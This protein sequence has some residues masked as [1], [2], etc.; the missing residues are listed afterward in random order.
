[1]SSLRAKK[2]GRY[3]TPP[4]LA[5]PLVEW[6][7]RDEKTRFLDPSFGGC[8]FLVAAAERLRG[9]GAKVPGRRVYGVDIDKRARDYL[10]PLYQAGALGSNFLTTDFLA[11]EPG[12]IP[13]GPFDTVCGNPPYVR[14]DLIADRK[15]ET[16]IDATCGANVTVPRNA[17]YWAYF[18]IHSIRCL[19]FGGR[20]AMI[21]P[22]SFLYADYANTIWSHIAANFQSIVVAALQERVF[23]DSEESPVILFADGFGGCSRVAHTA[24]VERVSELHRLLRRENV[25]GSTRVNRLQ[26]EKP[27][28]YGV[29]KK[30]AARIYG[31]IK[32]SDASSCLGDWAN[33]KIGVVTGCNQFFALSES[34]R[35]KRQLPSVLLSPAL[36]RG[37]DVNGL[38]FARKDYQSIRKKGRP[39]YLLAIDSKT[40]PSKSVAACI[41]LGVRQH[42][43][44]RFKCRI[45][46]PWYSLAD[47]SS[48]DAFINYMSSSFPHVILNEADVTCTN[49]IHRVDFNRSVDDEIARAIAVAS[50]SSV[51]Q[52]SIEMVGRSY[53]GGVLKLEPSEAKAMLLVLPS[54]SNTLSKAFHRVNRELRRG[55]KTAAM[56]S[57]DKVLLKEG[58]LPL[59]REKVRILREAWAA[60]V[61]LR[62]NRRCAG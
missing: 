14:H 30:R 47:L 60:L 45:R 15:L 12:E 50:V 37:A 19:K 2:L 27:W 24:I 38:T 48:C 54:S 11:L 23:Y 57:A 62:L 8:S 29:I 21:L 55:N 36:I 13:G 46:D 32:S 34:E 25:G 51:T 52:L 59:D 20:M 16:A 49:S 61:R 10:T 39:C 4:S 17:S 41:R 22:T 53:G 3:Y 26:D 5:R 28:N 35:R 44:R 40:T 56:A 31:Q 42:I 6:A 1:L 18:L 43:D 58:D 9:L 33:V 7:I